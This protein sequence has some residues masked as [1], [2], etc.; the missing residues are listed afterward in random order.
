MVE[1]F[2]ELTVATHVHRTYLRS[3]GS[4][5]NAIIKCNSLNFSKSDRIREGR[6]VN[7]HVPYKI[8]SAIA[9]FLG[10]LVLRGSDP[11]PDRSNG[12]KCHCGK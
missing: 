5:C 1:R 6:E 3:Y 4:Q 11:N 2:L 10:Y 12:K 7:S 8:K 9:T